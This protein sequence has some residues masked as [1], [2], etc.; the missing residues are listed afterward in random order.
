VSRLGRAVGCGLVG[1]SM[2]AGCAQLGSG[3]GSTGASSD[4]AS[5]VRRT[6]SLLDDLGY[7]AGPA[8]GVMG[9]RTTNAV[10]AFQSAKNLEPD[11]RITPSLL[12]NLQ[13]SETAKSEPDTQPGPPAVSVTSE[14][15]AGSPK[16][17]QG[18]DRRLVPG[19]HVSIR[20][21]DPKGGDVQRDL[22]IA[23]DG[24]LALPDGGN[25]HAAGMRTPDLENAVAL[26]ALERYMHTLSVKVHVD[27]PPATP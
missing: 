2:M 13:L 15:A 1:F 9:A 7:D 23:P 10:R 11:G 24:N 3:G 12:H 5:L 26:A 6:Q 16:I 8:D 19:D 14:P 25:I 22:T 20:I 27:P 17:P 21:S 4:G 18:D